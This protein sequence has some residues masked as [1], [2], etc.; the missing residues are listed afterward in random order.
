MSKKRSTGE[1]GVTR[2][3]FL[4][5]GGAVAAAAQVGAVAGAGLAAGRDP[6]TWTGWQHLGDN[7]QFV[8]RKPL[9]IDE[10]PY[11]IVGQTR[12]PTAVESVFDR[13]SLIMR[14]MMSR[15]G[16]RMRPPE[17]PPEAVGDIPPEAA[18]SYGPPQM[19]MPPADQFTGSLAAYYGKHPEVYELDRVRMESILPKK[20]RDEAKYGDYYTL[21]N[22]WSDCWSTGVPITELPEVSDFKTGGRMGG[23]RKIREPVPFKSPRHASRL[24]KKVAHQFGASMVG[25]TRMNPD[26]CYSHNLRGSKDR[27]HWEVPRHWEYVIAFGVPH[28]WEQV[29]SNP[30]CGTSFD[31]Y[32]RATIAAQRLENFIKGLG[33]PARRHSPM[34]GYDLIAVPFLVAAGL[35]QQGR[36]GIVITPETGSNFRAA[37]ITTNLPMEIDKP[38]DFGVNEFCRD[39]RIC[40]DICPS[41]SISFEDS[42][43]KM[44]TRGYRHWEINQTSCFNYWMQSMGGL[45]CRLCLIACPYSRKNN[46]VHAM[47]REIDT[48]DPTG[49]ANDSFTW[50]QKTFFKWPRAEEYMPPPDGRFAT[51]REPPEWLK[52]ENYLDIPFL[53]PTKGE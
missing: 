22:A 3:D 24:I 11:E 15:R 26:W 44:T 1:P 18:P 33:Y 17:K 2:R 6:S 45:G 8:D 47:A 19:K 30:N 7:T 32:S 13:G 25:I 21:I 35:G 29:N 14:D 41:K 10:L 51:F 20:R 16:G 43:E 31:A 4:K 38:I 36:H 40:A 39:C 50:M 9:E 48:H 53:D 42:N 23:G 34:D 52:T 12:R 28:Q 37:F 49:L 46:W 5:I 27:G